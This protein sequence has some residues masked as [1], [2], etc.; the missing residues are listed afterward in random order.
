MTQW[1]RAGAP[2]IIGAWSVE[3]AGWSLGDHQ[4]GRSRLDPANLAG[5]PSP[6]AATL[7]DRVDVTP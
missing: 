6:G 4:L 7:V 2:S 5:T 3:R 1:T